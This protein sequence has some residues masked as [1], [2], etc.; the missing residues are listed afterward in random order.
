MMQLFPSLLGLAVPLRPKDERTPAKYW[1]YSF[2]LIFCYFYRCLFASICL[3]L[4]YA[5]LTP[6][7]KAPI[8][9]ARK[10]RPEAAPAPPPQALTPPTGL[11]FPGPPAR[12]AQPQFPV[13]GGDTETECKAG[14][15]GRLGRA[16]GRR[17]RGAARHLG[18]AVRRRR[19]RRCADRRLRG[20]GG[21]VSELRRPP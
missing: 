4:K 1:Y 6:A 14:R 21:E 19:G 9:G 5:H 17:A 10:P 12:R 8:C 11:H 13:I 18:C 16:A 3:A 2:S 15:N 7:E 20:G